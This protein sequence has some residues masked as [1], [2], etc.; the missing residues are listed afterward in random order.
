MPKPTNLPL[1]RGSSQLP[2]QYAPERAGTVISSDVAR[3]SRATVPAHVAH[4]PTKTQK[5]KPQGDASSSPTGQRRPLLLWRCTRRD[6]VAAWTR[7]LRPPPHPARDPEAVTPGTCR[8]G[9]WP[10]FQGR[11]VPLRAEPRAENA[12]ASQVAS[13]LV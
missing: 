11:S 8:L 7:L 13:G 5:V 12:A 3:R 4:P 9:M 2:C 10:R 1:S 6:E